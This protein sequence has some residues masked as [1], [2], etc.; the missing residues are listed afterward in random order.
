MKK[1][2]VLILIMLISVVSNATNDTINFS[3][4]NIVDIVKTKTND[5]V[6]EYDDPDCFDYETIMEQ[7]G[8]NISVDYLL[9]TKEMQSKKLTDNLILQSEILIKCNELEKAENQLREAK[10]ICNEYKILDNYGKCNFLFKNSIGFFT[11][12]YTIYAIKNG[13]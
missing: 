7:N 8:D 3:F 2:T 10:E 6:I 5:Y 4:S 1:I 11:N 12:L 9:E 13:K